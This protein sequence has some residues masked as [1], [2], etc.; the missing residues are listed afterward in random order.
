MRSVIPPEP[1]ICQSII[2]VPP[3][4]VPARFWLLFLLCPGWRVQ[5]RAGYLVVSETPAVHGRL[6]APSTSHI[7]PCPRSAETLPFGPMAITMVCPP[8]FGI[9]SHQHYMPD[10]VLAAGHGGASHCL[11]DMEREARDCWSRETAPNQAVV[12]ASRQPTYPSN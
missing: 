1:G 11:C 3:G 9:N 2:G 7:G 4:H 10:T 12:G 6:Q 5:C 8:S